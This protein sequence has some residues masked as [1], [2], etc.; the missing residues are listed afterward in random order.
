[1]KIK[2]SLDRIGTP[3]LWNTAPLCE[4][5][6]IEDNQILQNKTYYIKGVITYRGYL[7]VLYKGFEVLIISYG[8]GWLNFQHLLELLGALICLRLQLLNA[9]PIQ[10]YTAQ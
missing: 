9:S 7:E 8:I 1:M 4:L 3:K 10:I 2:C 5:Y 6:S